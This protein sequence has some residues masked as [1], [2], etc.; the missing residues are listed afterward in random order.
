MVKGVS[1]NQK[2]AAVKKEISRDL[3]S[4]QTPA[5]KL[6]WNSLRNKRLNGIKFRR[7]QV[8]AGY[9]VDFY[10]PDSGLAIELDGSAHENQEFYDAK[11]DKA[12]N[13]IGITILRFSNEEAVALT[14]RTLETIN[15]EYVKLKKKS[16]ALNDE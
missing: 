7:Q 14:E 12:L 8:I 16:D 4:E 9:I 5:E 13:N 2:V 6:L 10:N 15:A 11:R 3:R 1:R